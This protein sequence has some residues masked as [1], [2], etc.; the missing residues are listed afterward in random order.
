VLDQI[1]TMGKNPTGGEEGHVDAQTQS[2]PL[3][4][5]AELFAT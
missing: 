1:R 2:A 3:K 4:V 5:L